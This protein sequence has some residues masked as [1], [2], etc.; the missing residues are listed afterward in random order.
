MERASAAPARDADSV[1]ILEPTVIGG[2]DSLEAVTAHRQGFTVDVVD[3]LTWSAMSGNDFASYRAIIFGDP[4]CTPGTAPLA[5]AEANNTVWGAAIDGNVIVVGTDAMFH[6]SF[7][8]GGAQGGDE[9]TE[10]AIAFAGDI[11]DKTGLYVALSCYY[12]GVPAFTPVP[13][14]DAFG[15]FTVTGFPG[16]FDQAH[17]VASHPVFVGLTDE[18]LSNWECSVHEAIDSFPSSFLPLSIA[19]G[20]GGEG[21]MSFPDGSFGMPYIVARG[22]DL[23]PILCGNGLIDV[24][25]E[26]DDG[27]TDNFDGCSAQCTAEVLGMCPAG[28]GFWKNH[29]ERWPVAELS[30]GSEVY[31]AREL[32]NILKTRVK[33]DA[34]I[35]LAYQ[36]IAAKL[37]LANG[38]RNPSSVIPTVREMDALLSSI[39]GRIPLRVRSRTSDGQAMHAGAWVLDD[40]NNG[41]YSPS[42]SE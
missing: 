39:G 36:L 23:S 27:N 20:L 30:L 12:H 14:L 11:D 9:L 5:A 7:G 37:N 34:S 21:S 19:V 16:C 32:I 41:V 26:C 29:P 2:I 24:G 40:Y 3:A 13:V 6:S 35:A 38:S 22:Q 1:L 25:E 31:T 8:P 17:L 15:R 4:R 33:G 28:Q 42:C 10:R 18:I